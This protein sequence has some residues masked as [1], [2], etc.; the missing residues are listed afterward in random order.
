MSEPNFYSLKLLSV[1]RETE[2]A[3][4]ITFDVPEELDGKFNFIQGQY[5]TLRTILKEEDIRRS[6][7]ICAGVDD[8]KL[9]VAIKRIEGG[10][11]SSFAFQLAAGDML[12]VMPPQC[13]FHTPLSV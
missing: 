6:Y 4:C 5:L 11:F 2:S 1:K 13:T 7:S 12:Y 10:A 3:V 8:N 9:Q